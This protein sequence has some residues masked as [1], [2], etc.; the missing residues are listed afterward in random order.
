[1]NVP[2]DTT[3]KMKNAAYATPPVNHATKKIPVKPVTQV[4]L[5]PPPLNSV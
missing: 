4:T 3:K 2:K 5:F 1:M